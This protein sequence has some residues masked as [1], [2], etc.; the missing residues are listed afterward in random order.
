M[1]L[2]DPVLPPLLAGHPVRSPT[3]P[4]A[5]AC[6]QAAKAALGAGDLVWGRATARAELALV[7][8]PDVPLATAVQMGAVAMLSLADALGALCP[9]QVGV[10]MRWPDTILVNGGEAAKVVLAAPSRA[11]DDVPPWLVVGADV[12][13]R[14]EDRR[15][16]PGDFVHLTAL[17]EEGA[18]EVTR[19]HVIEAFARYFLKWLTTWQD[20]GFRP[21]QDQWL[22]RAEGREG[23]AEF[24]TQSGRV[25]GRVL[26][27]D[28]SGN[29]IL[30]PTMGALRTLSY[31]DHV[32]TADETLRR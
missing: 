18:G 32:T 29:L 7:L 22:F 31:I 17:V 2:P 15:R 13:V 23:P 28:A 1:P 30:Q 8:E 3:K 12:R 11:T 5:Y 20:E 26:G 14:F 16:E 9:P 19:T 6:R 21:V 25:R 24:A 4:L 27:L 10:H